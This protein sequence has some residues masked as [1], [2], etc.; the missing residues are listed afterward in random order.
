[1][2]K[3]ILYSSAVV[4]LMAASAA[5]MSSCGKDEVVVDYNDNTVSTKVFSVYDRQNN[6]LEGARVE[7]ASGSGVTGADGRAVFQMR[8][9]DQSTALFTVSKDGYATMKVSGGSSATL[10]KPVG[11]LKGYITLVGPS[12]ATLSQRVEFTIST[13]YV[14]R[15]F[16]VEVSG[17]RFEITGLP[18]GVNVSAPSEL[19]VGGVKYTRGSSSDMTAGT[20]GAPELRGAVTYTAQ[21]TTSATE[22]LRVTSISCASAT[23]PLVINFSKEVDITYSG[24]Y[25]MVGYSVS[26]SDASLWSNGNKTLTVSPS[27]G[28]WT[29][30]TSI[31][32]DYRFYSTADGSGNRTSVS[33]DYNTTI[34]F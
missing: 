19:T 15:S 23:S 22:P 30:G 21:S 7:S 14:N 20:E 31:S 2:K 1:M 34:T 11:T 5:V 27:S 13:S 24:N 17:G 12:A 18:E 32:V 33:S 3:N 10:R 9:A 29:S 6:P 16:P 25:L 8:Q 4:A 28:S 26:V